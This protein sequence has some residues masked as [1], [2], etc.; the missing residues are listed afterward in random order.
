M[1]IEE[2]IWVSKLCAD[3]VSSIM[4]YPLSQ[5]VPIQESRSLL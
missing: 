4:K 3:E 2:E 1:M 5:R